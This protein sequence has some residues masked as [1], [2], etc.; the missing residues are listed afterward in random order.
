MLSKRA[1][2]ERKLPHIPAINSGQYKG[3]ISSRL[4]ASGEI[5]ELAQVEALQDEVEEGT[6]LADIAEH[7]VDRL[8]AGEVGEVAGGERVAC[9]A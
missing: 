2:S 4:V 1:P 5:S 8:V 3:A 6:G 9:G 7:G